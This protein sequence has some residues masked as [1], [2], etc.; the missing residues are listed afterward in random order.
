MHLKNKSPVVT[1]A[2]PIVYKTQRDQ[3]AF[4]R[5]THRLLSLCPLAVPQQ[6][7]LA[8]TSEH[9]A[10]VIQYLDQQ[11]QYQQ[12]TS[13]QAS[14]TT[15]RVEADGDGTI[16]TA[17]FR[18][19][20]GLDL[21]AT[22]RV[23]LSASDPL[24]RWNITIRNGAGIELVAVQYPFVVCAY[25][26]GGKPGTERLLLPH[27]FGQLIPTPTPQ[28]LGPD[29]STAWELRPENGSCNHYPGGQFAQ[30]LAYYNNR[31]GLYLACEDTAGNVKRFRTV[32]REPGM[33][34]G[35]AHIGDWP[36][37]GER[38]LEYDTVLGSFSGNWYTAAGQYRDWSLRQKWGTPLYRRT[39]VPSWLLESPP[40]ITIRPQGILDDGPV[41]PVKEFLP[42]EKCIALLAK[43]AR[44]IEAPLVA[45]MMGWE[46][47]GSWV[48]P[49]CFPP[50]G[51]DASIRR[52]TTLA[53]KRGWRVGSFCN[54][55][56]WVVGHNWNGYDGRTYY[57]QHG[58]DQ[59]VCRLPDGQA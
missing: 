7:F 36:K 39:D 13:H 49:D 12:L 50:I 25:R 43:I 21:E 2:N 9:P 26:L 42:Y 53:R 54:G 15:T 40:Y 3:L 17:V 34:I 32:H 37:R 19:I 55:T 31:A 10:F 27:G 29:C 57:K 56:R 38:T 23:R 35:V 51:G 24:S 1:A 22:T 28:M 20:A 4:D 41:L 30:F 59:S 58:G 47:G 44:R 33:R 11:R 5:R 8:S 16:L 18:G 45:V 46:R 14:T 52:F 6:E 48:Y